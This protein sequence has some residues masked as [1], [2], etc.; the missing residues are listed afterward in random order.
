MPPKIGTVCDC[1]NVTFD[2]IVQE[3]SQTVVTFTISHK[4]ADNDKNIC[5]DISH[6]D[7]LIK[8]TDLNNPN[9]EPKPNQDKSHPIE[10]GKDGAITLT[11]N[12]LATYGITPD[13]YVVENGKNNPIVIKWDYNTG[14]G[15]FVVKHEGSPRDIYWVMIKAGTDRCIYEYEL[16]EATTTTVAPTTTTTTTVAP[17]TTTTT[18]IA[19]TTEPPA[20]TPSPTTT[21]TTEPPAT[22]PSPTTTTEFPTTTPAPTTT[23]VPTTTEVT[24]TAE[25]STTATVA[26]T[27]A[28][29]GFCNDDCSPLFCVNH[30][31]ETYGNEEQQMICECDY[32]FDV[33]CHNL[34]ELFGNL[35]INLN[36]KGSEIDPN[37][38]VL[39]MSVNKLKECIA[40]SVCTVRYTRDSANIVIDDCNGKSDVFKFPD[41]NGTKNLVKR[42]SAFDRLVR[43]FLDRC[44]GSDPVS[45]DPTK[46]FGQ[47]TPNYESVSKTIACM[48]CEKQHANTALASY[49]GYSDI[50]H[51]IIVEGIADATLSKRGGLYDALKRQ[52]K[53]K[54][55]LDG[56][57]DD[58]LA[59]E[60]VEVDMSNAVLIYCF[61]YR[62]V[63]KGKTS[64]WVDGVFDNDCENKN[65]TTDSGVMICVRI[66]QG[67]C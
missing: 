30:F 31:F 52:Y 66:S 4:S 26:P 43:V 61:R 16:A 67:D 33:K 8:S 27:T 53:E 62:S 37:N 35:C 19:P 18:T 17:T 11:S 38:N 47:G 44:Y 15:T 65:A 60:C 56:T 7:F 1:N 50:Y 9:T 2:S 12:E 20:T 32:T 41:V 48:M 6:V 40:N 39:K 25:V 42:C 5:Q 46:H 24:T 55:A 28:E 29:Y 14:S 13:Y 23:D 58:K 49:T 22:T 63:L 10:H 21:T 57:L 54:Y 36:S 59:Q 3:K 51:K 34:N 64:D 45:S